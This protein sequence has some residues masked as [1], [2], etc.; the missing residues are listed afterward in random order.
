MSITLKIVAGALGGFILAFL[1][2]LIFSFSAGVDSD[3][4]ETA[5]GY[6]MLLGWLAGFGLALTA[7]RPAKSWRRIFA[8]SGLLAFALPIATVVF[9]YMYSAEVSEIGGTAGAAGAV[10]GGGMA[11]VAVG[12]VAFFVGAIFFALAYFIGRDR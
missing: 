11:T 2:A 10:I 6:G 1:T 7:Q 3:T 8:A 5:S 12:F 4:A 9:T